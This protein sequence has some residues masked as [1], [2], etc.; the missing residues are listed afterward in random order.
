MKTI[1]NKLF[2]ATAILALASC[3]DNTYLG[4][5][6]VNNTGN[7]GVISF[8]SSTGSLT[9]A[10]GADAAALLHNNFVVEG[11]KT[12]STT[13]SEVF[14]NYNVN[15]T[16]NTAATTASN[17]A[18]WEYVAQSKH[19]NS[20][21]SEQSI[22]YWDFAASQYDFW[23]YSLGGGSATVSALEPT[24]TLTTS[25]YTI[26]GSKDNLAKVYISDLVT[27][28]ASSLNVS[29][30]PVMG[31]EVELNFRSLV[32]KVR[33]G[34]YETIPGYS[35]KNVKFYTSSSA[36]LA[37]DDSEKNATLFAS[38]NNL[39]TFNGTSNNAE[40]TVKFP[41]IGKDNASNSDYNKA[42]VALSSTDKTSII[43][44]GT[45]SYGAKH[46]S[47][48]TTGD[49]W[50]RINSA[51]PTWA[52]ETSASAG[53]YSIVLPNEN[54]EVLTLRVDY[55][56]ESTDGSGEEITIHGATALVPSQYTQW[57][58]NFAYTYIFKISDNTNGKTD[59]NVDKVGLY[60]IT[61]DAVVENTTT[62]NQETITTVAT[63]SITTFSIGSDVITNNEY[64]T[65]NDIYVIATED[66]GTLKSMTGKAKLYDI[67]KSNN[68]FAATEAEVLASLTTYSTKTDGG[69]YTGRNSIVLDPVASSLDLDVATLPT[70][71]GRTISITAGQTAKIDKS[72]LT[73]GHYYA[74]VFDVTP[75]SPAI[76][77]EDKYE[78]VTP[79]SGTDVTMYY[80]DNTGSAKATGTA[81]GNTT[82]Y[83]KY[84]IVKNA[85]YAIKVIKIK[86]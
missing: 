63:P 15:Y 14:D 6:E 7:R 47:E 10:S 65:S 77:T 34:I 29:G 75:A 1:K 46:K 78:A 44:F 25:A 48:K 64:T 43:S 42:H 58:P 56:L 82:Y 33:V 18:N 84:T 80:I 62:G 41:T 67:T 53:D 32:T 23:A 81:D 20:A 24:A 4:D 17:T 19:A 51:Q 45:L 60:P 76:A 39:P 79:T 13:K 2:L 85:V 38:G 66:N 16:A 83:D 50:L 71:D 54:G 73:A 3:A 52:K 74:F 40:F 37:T 26:T 36:S 5:Q 68:A 9:R 72:K 35:V 59:V 30:K 49:I 70:I 21:A 28:Y 55:T 12:V 8:G 27:A 69:K 31:D 61:L 57:K 86:N 11:I 22:K